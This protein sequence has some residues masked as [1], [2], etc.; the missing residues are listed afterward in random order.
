MASS[1][2]LTI[3]WANRPAYNRFQVALDIQDACNLSGVVRE[4]VKIVDDAKARPVAGVEGR[5]DPAVVL[6]LDKIND[7]C[8]RYGDVDTESYSLADKACRAHAADVTAKAALTA[9]EQA[10]GVVS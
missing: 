6:V 3:F 7:M 8:C 1:H 5:R 4:F 9:I 2:D 10:L